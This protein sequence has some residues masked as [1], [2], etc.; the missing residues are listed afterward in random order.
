[1]QVMEA[2][3]TA[4][5]G[6]SAALLTAILWAF[7]S[8]F[9]TGASRR[10]GS[11]SV[12]VIRIAI[13]VLIIGGTVL[14]V[15]G[16]I[17]PAQATSSQIVWLA[18]SGIVGLVLGDTFLFRSLIILG[19]RLAT[20]IFATWPIMT[21]VLSWIFLT[22]SLSWIAVVGIAVAMTGIAWV[23]VEKQSEWKTEMVGSDRGSKAFGVAMALLG[24]FGQAAGLV[25]AKYAM[26]DSL[27]AIEASYI[28]MIA[29]FAVIWIFCGITG[30]L[31]R[32]LKSLS[33]RPAM[34]HTLG[35]AISGPFLGIWMSLVAITYTK[36]GI[37]AAI[38]ASVPVVII[39]I[40]IVVYR[41]LPSARAIVGALVTVAGISI[42]FLI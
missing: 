17:F 5:L 21:V 10:I 6:E 32:I 8:I 14:I 30:K 12:N 20:L 29:A 31:R 33:N 27:T 35:G 39:P 34:A 26:T 19:P 15:T 11:F 22:E 9:F 18:A 40:S 24:G 2:D 42:L 23:T 1:M 13:A 36:T 37:A 4:Y 28:R 25:M 41:Q 38:M 7:T 16:R 3:L